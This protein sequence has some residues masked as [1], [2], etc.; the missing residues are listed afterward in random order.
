VVDGVGGDS[1]AAAARD[2]FTCATAT[3]PGV[4]SAARCSTWLSAPLVDQPSVIHLRSA[5]V[6]SKLPAAV[7]AELCLA[8][9]R[10][11]S[12]SYRAVRGRHGQSSL[13]SHEAQCRLNPRGRRRGREAAAADAAHAQPR[14]SSALAATAAPS[15]TADLIS[16]DPP[17]WGRARDVFLLRD[18]PAGASWAPLVASGAR[19]LHHVPSALLGAWRS[20]GAEGLDWVRREPERP[21]PWL[22]LSLLPSLLLHSPVT[23]AASV[24]APPPLSHTER[25]AALLRG[26]FDAC[27]ADR[28]A[29]VCRPSTVPRSGPRRPP[30]PRD[31]TVAARRRAVRLA[32][33]GRLSAAARALRADPPAPQTPVVERTARGLFPPAAPDLATPASIEAGFPAE[34]ARAAEYGRRSAVPAAVR[35]DAAVLASRTAPR[36]S[37]SGPSGTRMEHLLA[38]GEEGRDALVGVVLLLTGEAA[39]TRVPAVATHALAGA[40]LLLLAK[41]GGVREDGR[42]SLQPIGMPEAQRKLDA[43]A[44]TA[45][46]RSS[47]ADLLSQGQLGVGVPNACER[48]LHELG[49]HLAHHPGDAV[50]Q[51]DFKNVFNLVSRPAAEAVMHRALPVL[52]PYLRWAYK[53]GGACVFEW[54]VDAAAPPPRPGAG[55]SV[56]P[57]PLADGSSPPPPRWWLR[58]ERGAQQGDPLGP[59]LHA[60]AMWLVLELLRADHPSVVVR[61]FHDDVVVVGPPAAIRG[62]FDA[63]ARLGGGV[64]AQLAP[65]K[66]VGWSPAGVAAPPG[67]SAQWTT[68]G[69]TQLSVPL[70]DADFVAAAVDGLATAQVALCAAIGELPADQLQMQLLRLRLYAEPQA[71]YSL[72]ALPLADGARLAGA[73]DRGAQRVL[74]GLLCD[75][76]DGAA[77]RAAVVERAALPPLMGGLGIGGRTAVAPA[78]AL[79]SRVDALR[80]G[81]AYSPALRATADALLRLPGAGGG[82]VVRPAG[83]ARGT[84]HAHAPAGAAAHRA[85]AP[86]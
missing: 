82:A 74:A 29:G 62:V 13:A 59:L 77:T 48:V 45:T 80:A 38:L 33:V 17:A 37:S 16:A 86:S 2:A 19:T 25:V 83:V 68:E 5:H 75:A 21:T 31:A 73:V 84:R 56:P 42:P 32:R 4:C 65:A 78:A 46:K 41:P 43:S 50:L 35:W 39:T 60:A 7:V 63:A 52:T 66:C 11:C 61:A 49:A 6:T 3:A 71:S 72:R 44:L 76:R 36:G 8:P 24:D 47:A 14:A 26:D 23:T 69:L 18:A 15:A 55:G 27:L 9:C 51:L 12:R 10:W 54:A 22:W 53:G 67:W 64:D 40:D 79:A 28:N 20:L 57:A 85:T 30:A 34:L 81:R 1:A 58:V 70:G